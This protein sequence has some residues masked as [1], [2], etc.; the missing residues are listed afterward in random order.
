MC[1][2]RA[3]CVSCAALHP[4]TL[5]YSPAAAY[6]Q[7]HTAGSFGIAAC[8]PI[9]SFPLHCCHAIQM[10]GI[11]AVMLLGELLLNRLPVNFFQSGWL[12]LW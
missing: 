11:N 5:L 6:T 3:A 12:A 4:F 1:C 9:P 10:H 8:S 2:L 7:M